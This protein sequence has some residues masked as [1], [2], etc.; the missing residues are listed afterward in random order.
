MMNL[1]N[2]RWH[3]YAP[4]CSP[5]STNRTGL[6]RLSSTN[7]RSLMH[8]W[9]SVTWGD[10][11]TL[12][13]GYDI[14]KSQQALDGS[15]PVVSSGG[16]SSF[17]DRS[18]NDGPGVIMGRKGT[19][20]R[21]YYVNGP[22]WPH[23]TTLWVSDFKGN[24]P[25]F[26]YYALQ[27]IDPAYLNVGSASPT[28]NRNHVHPISVVW[29]TTVDQQEAIAEVLGALD[30]KIAA[31]DHLITISEILAIAY[32]SCATKTTEVGRI[33]TH[34]TRS[35]SPDKFQETVAHYSLPAFDSSA[36]PSVEPAKSIK[37]N[38]FMLANPS[39]LISKLNPRIPRIWNIPEIGNIQ[40]VASTEF[41]VLEPSGYSTS[42]LWSL[43]RQP[44][45]MDHIASRVAG[46]SGSHQ[47]VKP[48]EILS[49]PVGDPE[50]LNA[51]IRE[52]IDGLGM[53]I[54]CAR[55]ESQVLAKTRDEILPLLMSGKLRI[56][57]AEKKVEAIAG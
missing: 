26:V 49:A 23:D 21:V 19:L 56:K 57:D 40:A 18:M 1:T 9:K 13:R 15:I 4:N 54:E 14:T 5:H 38:K 42:V 43:L 46:T 25:R 50:S 24:H 36:Q 51:G 2:R 17:H 47:R 10:V 22:F 37:S 45:V 55:K 11:I 7:W 20:G 53:R 31:N 6:R 39:V 34:S 52:L 16:I 35:L 29:P 41:V 32:A 44:G 30:D 28:L 33:A 3:V 12:Q 8:E 27:S 48:A